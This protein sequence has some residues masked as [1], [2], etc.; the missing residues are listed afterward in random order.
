M[1]IYLYGLPGVGKNYIGEI[2]KNKFN[3]NFIDA[4]DYLPINM[5]YLMNQRMW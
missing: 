4:D 1:I 5:N 2:F 3:F